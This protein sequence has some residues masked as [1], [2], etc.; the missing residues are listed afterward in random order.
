MKIQRSILIG[1]LCALVIALPA[2]AAPSKPNVVIM[3]TD[4]QGTLDAHCYGSDDLYT[5]AMD[6]LAATGVRFTQA[7]SHAVCC[8]AR[9][10]LMTG[11][12]PQR[13]GVNDWTKNRPSDTTKTVMAREE[14]TLAE[15]LRDA[16]YKTAL[17]GKWHL[18]ADLEHE[19]TEQGF[20]EFLGHRGGFIDNYTH[21]FMHGTG[22]H[23]L[24]EQK[25]EIF[26][27]GEYFPDMV[28]NRALEY[29][30]ENRDNPF[31][32]YLAFNL[33]HYPEQA[34]AKFDDR[35]AKLEMPRQSYA[36]VVSTV[37]DRMGQVLKKLDELGLRENTIVVFQSDNGHSVEN[38]FVRVENHNSGV[39]NGHYYGANRGGGNTGKW[40]GHKGQLLEG[41]IRVPAIISYPKALP[42]GVVRNQ[43]VTLMDWMPTILTLCGVAYPDVKFDGHDILPVIQDNAPSPYQAMHWQWRNDWAVREGD[44]KLLKAGKELSLLNLVGGEPEQTNHIADHPEIAARLQKLYDAWAAE[45]FPAGS[46]N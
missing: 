23:D 8:P 35:Y 19:P 30:E 33:P 38:A 13:S 14:V 36:K 28:T 11:R 4:D 6:E 32:L 41:G 10:M 26:R 45:V 24:Y 39:A 40:I 7:Y 9:A 2:A 18:G 25:E 16:G 20:D 46:E 21:F 42:Q 12:Y 15:A 17:F 43:A 5:P 44:W 22:F 3:L 29:I 27:R 31:F 1:C 37:D 34:D